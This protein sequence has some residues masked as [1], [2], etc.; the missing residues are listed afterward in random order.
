MGGFK[1][2]KD[3]RAEKRAA[4]FGKLDMSERKRQILMRMGAAP[5]PA[6][7][8]LGLAEKRLK[9]GV[10]KRFAKIKLAPLPNLPNLLDGCNCT[11][12]REKRGDTEG[13]KKPFD[14]MW[15]FCNTLEKK[16]YERIGS[17]FY[18]RVYLGKDKTKVLKIGRGTDGW[19]NYVSWA[20]KNGYG[21]T[22]APKLYSAKT[23]KTRDGS[24]LMSSMER[25]GDV[26]GS[27]VKQDAYAKFSMMTLY[28]NN[29][30]QLAGTLAE[31]AQPGAK[32][33]LAKFMA[34]FKG[35]ARM[36]MHEGNWMT[37]ENGLLVLTDPVASLKDETLRITARLKTKDFEPMLMAA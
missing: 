18:S 1:N 9:V 19:L 15:S 20:N 23:V 29:D 12:C 24:F 16:G 17:G 2:A 13:D 26:V 11:Q 37:R 8:E 5:L 36:D 33:F 7:V 35:K 32:D 6:P 25:L 21:G 31:V 34:E 14:S 28:A 3:R 30:N 22:L 4:F 10:P 27:N